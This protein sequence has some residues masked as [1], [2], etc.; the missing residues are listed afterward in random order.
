[1]QNRKTIFFIGLVVFFIPILGFP[2]GF[3]TFLQ[4]IGGFILMVLAGRKT[5]EKRIIKDR[6]PR[7]RKEKNP[8]FVESSYKEEAPLSTTMNE[9]SE[10]NEREEV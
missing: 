5:I 10:S 1:M 8:V 3:E 2:G 7:K 6:K 4:I 9:A